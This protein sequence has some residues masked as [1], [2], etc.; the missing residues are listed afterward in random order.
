MSDV[1]SQLKAKGYGTIPVFTTDLADNFKTDLIESSDQAWANVHPYFASVSIT[2]AAEWTW[3]FYE[4]H[5]GKPARTAGKIG[6]ISETGWP[7]KG[8][9]KGDS[10]PSMANLQ[11]FVD[12]FVCQTNTKGIP[13]YFFE[14]GL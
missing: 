6:V 9:A 13:Y 14:V 11:R 12:D 10:I 4:E 5:I 2:K 1:R 7:T 8:D 3:N